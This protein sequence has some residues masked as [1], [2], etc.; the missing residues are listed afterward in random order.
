VLDGHAPLFYVGERG[1]HEWSQHK[2]DIL[3]LCMG[4]IRALETAA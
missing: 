4:F 2:N 1:G 3:A